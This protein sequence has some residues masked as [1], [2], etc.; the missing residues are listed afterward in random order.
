M[1]KRKP[2]KDSQ[3]ELPLDGPPPPT[4]DTPPAATA[5]TPRPAAMAPADANGADVEVATAKPLN[6]ADAPL[7][8]H[9]RS[10][11]LD[12]ASYVILDR[13]SRTSTTA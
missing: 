7:A 5:A 6:P 11:F 2:P 3:P 1:A 4:P 8:K 9:Y 12:Y 13:P 10:W